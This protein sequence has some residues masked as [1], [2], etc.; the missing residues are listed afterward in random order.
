MT[1]LRKL[2]PYL[3]SHWHLLGLALVLLVASGVLETVLITLLAPI[4]NQLAAG[5][6][7][8]GGGEDKFA[9]LQQLLGLNQNNLA[10][11]ADC[12]VAFAFFKG[13]FLCFAEY[14]MSYT[15]QQVVAALR[16]GL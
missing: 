4:F 13:L 11:I 9:F 3:R 8:V 1:D 7:V 12:L 6:G 2:L 10:R 5:A 14:S 16:K 15:G